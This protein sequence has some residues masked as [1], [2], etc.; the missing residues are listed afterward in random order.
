[1]TRFI[2]IILYLFSHQYFLP[3]ATISSHGTTATTKKE[4]IH[5]Q[6]PNNPFLLSNGVETSGFRTRA[7]AAAQLLYRCFR[8]PAPAAVYET[9]RPLFVEQGLL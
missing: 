7:V 8:A 6:H 5:S 1:M 4:K 3:N 9:G 2:F